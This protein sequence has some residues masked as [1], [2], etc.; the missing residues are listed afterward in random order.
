MR[1]KLSLTHSLVITTVGKGVLGIA[2]GLAAC[3]A[4]E[5][6]FRTE[7]LIFFCSCAIRALTKSLSRPEPL[8]LACSSYSGSGTA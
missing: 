6:R 1:F 7:S 4:R 3:L 5:R 2:A 8:G